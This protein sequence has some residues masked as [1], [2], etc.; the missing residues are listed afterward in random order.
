MPLPTIAFTEVVVPA[1]TNNFSGLV[2]LKVGVP[3]PTDPSESITI[4]CKLLVRNLMLTL[5]VV[6][7]KLV[8][9][10]EPPLPVSSQLLVAALSA[11]HTGEAGVP[12]F[13]LNKL[14]VVLKTNNPVAGDEIAFCC[15]VVILGASK[16]LV[17]L[18][19]SSIALA[20]GVD[21]SVLIATFC[22]FATFRKNGN[23]NKRHLIK[24]FMMML[25]F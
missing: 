3:M 1:S 11:V 7:K 2:A 20:S 15:V 19:M 8:A 24:F 13:T 14:S 17:V 10:L 23:E 12:V 6:P 18:F 25:D 9:E 16:P 4:R 21:P 5:S 22:A